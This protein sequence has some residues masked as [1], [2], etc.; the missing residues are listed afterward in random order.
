VQRSVKTGDAGGDCAERGEKIDF[1][2]EISKIFVIFFNNKLT[3][4]PNLH[5]MFGTGESWF[6]DVT[7][8]IRHRSTPNRLTQHIDEQKLLATAYKAKYRGDI[9]FFDE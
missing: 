6:I 2:L 7:L 9:H 3:T 4:H 8:M 5:L 1:Y